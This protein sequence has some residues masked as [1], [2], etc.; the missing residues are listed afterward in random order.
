M[1]LMGT[2]SG[3]E[4]SDPRGT[5]LQVARGIRDASINHPTWHRSP[6]P[7]PEMTSTFSRGGLHCFQFVL[8]YLPTLQQF[9]SG[10]YIH[11]IIYR[12]YNRIIHKRRLYSRKYTKENIQYST[13]DVPTR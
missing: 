10:S 4:L 8:H 11:V 13:E 7:P 3:S 6:A 9:I 1:N 5:P 12:L 2:L